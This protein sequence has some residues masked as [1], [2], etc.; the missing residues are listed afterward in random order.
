[1]T[2]DHL[3]TFVRE[4]ISKM[5][6]IVAGLLDGDGGGSVENVEEAVGQALSSVGRAAMRAVL[7]SK[8]PG[9]RDLRINGTRH[10]EAA[11]AEREYMSLFGPV[12]VMRGIYRS[13]R[14]G[15][16][17]CPMEVRA[18]ILENFWTRRAAKLAV[19]AVTDMSPYGAC[20]FFAELGGMRPSR[21][22]L[23]RLP[24]ALSR[25]WEANR[26]HV[27]RAVREADTIPAEAVSVA[28]SIDGVML[29]MRDGGKREKKA[30]ARAAGRPDKGPAG[31]R[32]AGC[33][34]VT[35]YDAKGERL[36]T[37]RFGRMPE[38]KMATLR[39]SL[40]AE[41]AHVRAQR[42]DLTV[43][44]V[45]DGDPVLW[46]F[47]DELKPD[48]AVVDFYHAAEHLKSALDL[49]DEAS[50]VA[51]QERFKRLRR[52]LKTRKN[53]V[54]TITR[55]LCQ[56]PPRRTS[57]AAL[58]RRG[59]RYFNRHAH[60]M[61]YP[62]MRH[63]RLPIGSGVVEGTC[64]WLVSDRMKRTGMRWDNPGGQAILTLR[65]LV[66]SD[67]FETAW[68]LLAGQVAPC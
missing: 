56:K 64:R 30:R 35:F 63:H 46:E 49:T 19:L 54:R 21:S 34:S 47:L 58:Y 59:I 43:V 10:W 8:D 57:E 1:M 7:E 48:H 18:G 55:S 39:E 22:S 26:D 11:R 50:A 16:T 42:P 31:Y 20:H 61:N 23:D 67:R 65:A 45:A 15:P 9:G 29:P 44:A 5:T 32:E 27:E 40:A 62:K 4:A 53:G 41:L 51:T 12:R 38:A 25:R 52:G 66:H 37:V 28:V 17:V 68:P 13:V 14:N 24:K 6:E 2:E 33:G 3:P 36:K 60:R